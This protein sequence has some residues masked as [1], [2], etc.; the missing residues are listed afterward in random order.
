MRELG[1]LACFPHAPEIGVEVLSPSKTEAEIDEKI[2]LYF[3][4]GASEVWL[5]AQDGVIR[6]FTF[7]TPRAARASKLCPRFP[8]SINLR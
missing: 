7:E 6:F 1:K 4:A 8:K 5:C 2:A 3:D